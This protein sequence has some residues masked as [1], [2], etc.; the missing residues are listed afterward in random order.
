MR[1]CTNRVLD[2][3]NARFETHILRGPKEANERGSEV[4][5]MREPRVA[6][7]G[8]EGPRRAY[9][10]P[11]LGEGLNDSW[12]AKVFQRKTRAIPAILPGNCWE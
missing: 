9:K 2:L 7:R 5:E 6:Q 12:K 4:A 10:G 1:H 8:P 11:E 3:L